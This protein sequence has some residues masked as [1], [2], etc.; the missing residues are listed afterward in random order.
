MKRSKVFKVKYQKKK[1]WV[2]DTSQAKKYFRH[3]TLDS[4]R[5]DRY[6]IFS[7]SLTNTNDLNIVNITFTSI[8]LYNVIILVYS[9]IMLVKIF[10][11]YLDKNGE[12][13]HILIVKFAWGQRADQKNAIEFWRPMDRQ[14]TGLVRLG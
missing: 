4:P 13:Y 12:Y 9:S 11:F 3:N 5:Q 2:G 7:Q 8:Y 6:K 10:S 1:F 14:E